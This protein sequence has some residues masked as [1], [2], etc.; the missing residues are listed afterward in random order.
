MEDFLKLVETSVVN[1]MY[2]LQ[3]LF[4]VYHRDTHMSCALVSRIIL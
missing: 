1:K 3:K 4:Y 2:P